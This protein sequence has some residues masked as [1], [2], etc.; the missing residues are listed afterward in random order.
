MVSG[1]RL[2]WWAGVPQSLPFFPVLV[3][4]T[5]AAMSYPDISAVVLDASFDDL[6]PLALKV[7]PDSCSEYSRRPAL[8]GVGC[9]GAVSWRWFAFPR[10]GVGGPLLRS[11]LPHE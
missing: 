8:Q 2:G 7:M 10:R 4:A 1:R 5:W 11:R 3:P 6:V 9:P